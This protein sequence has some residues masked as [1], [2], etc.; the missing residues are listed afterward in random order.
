LIGSSRAE[1]K[2]HNGLLSFADIKFNVA[3]EFC[4]SNLI[5]TV[6]HVVAPVQVAVPIDTAA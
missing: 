2:P 1:K 5:E 3:Y 4:D 6:V